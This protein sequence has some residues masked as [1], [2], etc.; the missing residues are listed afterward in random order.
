M[1]EIDDKP[2]EIEEPEE[3]IEAPEGIWMRG[4]WMIVLALLFGLGETIL[5]VTAL[6][7]WLWMLF[8][9]E[10][11]GFLVDFGAD[12][13]AWMRDVARFQTGA[14]EDKPFPWARWGE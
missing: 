4:L 10:K 12:M 7:Q 6:V 8:T 2:L 13:G 9:K 3:R 1:S 5:A 11:N 14:T